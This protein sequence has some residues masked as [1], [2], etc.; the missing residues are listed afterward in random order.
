[1]A[2]NRFASSKLGSVPIG[3]GSLVQRCLPWRR[4]K[5][6][7][8]GNSL[9]RFTWHRDNIVWLRS[10]G[11]DRAPIDE[12][13]RRVQPDF[14]LTRRLAWKLSDKDPLNSFLAILAKR[15][16]AA[17]KEDE[18][19]PSEAPPDDTKKAGSAPQTKGKE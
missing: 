3:P 14:A 4:G 13:Y 7:R 5:Q 17:E 2:L 1:M 9:Q 15:G 10:T 12:L 18:I 16:I 19:M 8:P 11:I 6:P